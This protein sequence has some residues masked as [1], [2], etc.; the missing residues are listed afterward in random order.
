MDLENL[1]AMP[2]SELYA[3]LHAIK[4]E[5]LRRDADGFADLIK[6]HLARVDSDLRESIARGGGAVRVTFGTT[7]YDNGVFY[8]EHAGSLT[9]ADGSTVDIDI[10]YTSAADMMTELSEAEPLNTYSVLAVD[11]TTGQISHTTVGALA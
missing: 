4:A 2:D 9:L 11:L 7:S 5:I 1:R 10:A 6:N 8:D 3:T